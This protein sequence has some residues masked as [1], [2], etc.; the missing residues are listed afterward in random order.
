MELIP[1]PWGS[2]RLN[3]QHSFKIN[4]THSSSCDDARISNWE[5]PLPK[6]SAS[7]MRFE[8]DV[9][10]VREKDRHCSAR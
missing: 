1:H 3:S 9:M 6:P 10:E 2:N 8:R 5:A 7:E 4:P